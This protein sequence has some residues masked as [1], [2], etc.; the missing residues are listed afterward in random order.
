MRETTERPEAVEANTVE[1]VGTNQDKIITKTELLINDLDHYKIMSN[2]VSPYGDG[3]AAKRI[4]DF[5]V[6]NENKR[7]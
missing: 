3:K 7:I 4:S 1:L 5:L 6:K 2:A